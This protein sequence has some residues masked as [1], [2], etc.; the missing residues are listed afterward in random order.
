MQFFDIVDTREDADEDDEPMDLGDLGARG[1]PGGCS[2]LLPSG[3]SRT[4]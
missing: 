2:S 1:S 4:S 3:W